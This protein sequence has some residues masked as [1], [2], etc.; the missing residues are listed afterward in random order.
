MLF[1]AIVA[2]F[3]IRQTVAAYIDRAPQCNSDDC[4][5]HLLRKEP[6][7]TPF[8]FRNLSITS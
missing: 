3:C 8:P 4:F 1:L 6:L 7:E 5:R 2:I